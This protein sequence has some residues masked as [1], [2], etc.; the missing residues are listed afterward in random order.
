MLRVEMLANMVRGTS[1]NL[2]RA[3]KRLQERAAV[4][5]PKNVRTAVGDRAYVVNTSKGVLKVHLKLN[6][7]HQGNNRGAVV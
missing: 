2:D 5:R 7:Q 6:L 4:V 1:N 3:E